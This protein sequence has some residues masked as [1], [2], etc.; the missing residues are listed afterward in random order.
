MPLLDAFF[1]DPT[2]LDVWIA[3]RCDRSR[4]DGTASNPYDGGLGFAPAV[5]VSLITNINEAIADSGGVPHG[6]SEGDMVQISGV[7]GQ[8]AVQ[9][10]RV[11]GVYDVMPTTFKFARGAFFNEPSGFPTAARVT[12]LFDEVL[13]AVPPY[14]RIHIGP[15]GIDGN[16][17]VIP[18]QT[19]GFAPQGVGNWQPKSGQKLVGAGMDVTIV[20]LVGAGVVKLEEELVEQ[21]Y[22][23]IGMPI[24]PTGTAPSPF[25]A[26]FEISDLTI[27]CNADNQPLRGQGTFTPVACGAVRVF[28]SNSRVRRVKAINWGTKS[29]KESAFVISLITASAETS[30]GGGQPVVQETASSGIEDCV[31]IQ[32]VESCAREVTVLH[33]G[34]RKNST[35]QAQAFATAPF[36]RKNFVDG[37]LARPGLDAGSPILVP[38]AFLSSTVATSIDPEFPDVGLFVSKRPHLRVANRRYRFYNPRNSNSIWNGY[39]QVV[40]V[41]DAKTLILSFDQ[42]SLSDLDSSLVVLGTE[43]RGVGVS[44]SLGAVVEQNQIHNCWI[45]G[46]YASPLDDSVNAPTAPPTLEREERLDSFNALNLRSL[47]VRNNFYKNV[48]VGPYWNMGG[49]S[50]AVSGNT[51]A[52]VGTG[53]VTVTTLKHHH[54][55]LGARVRIEAASDAHYEGVQ[56]VTAVTETTF[57]YQLAPALGLSSGTGSYRVVSGV[58]FLTIDGNTIE[59]ADLDETEFAIKEYPLLDPSVQTYRPFGLVVG[60]NGS[61]KQSGARVHRQVFIR[62]NNIRYGDGIRH[63]TLAG[64]GPPAGASMQLAGIEQLHVTNNVVDVNARIAHRTHRCGTVRFFHNVRPDG[65]LRR[66]WQWETNGFYDEPEA[67]AEDAFVLRLLN[68]G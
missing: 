42:P 24:T 16:G 22:H 67:V 64:L 30:D 68:G 28:G 50:G 18:F 48:A 37:T 66:G 46:P 17:N 9:W 29:I 5:P 4:G 54:L 26:A 19:R 45:G 14:T 1:V 33:L 3:L 34:G 44:S 13:R 43:I 2:R 15:S 21:H 51:L 39:Y 7:T 25:L 10:N 61:G 8:F 40:A 31:A 27:D 38:S 52:Y 6:L 47:V 58:D 59:L 49:V 60:D 55:W 23:A 57:K 32:P 65:E 63:A 53:E 41:Q 35:T 36:V 12:F 62:N 11:F 20:Q 56:T